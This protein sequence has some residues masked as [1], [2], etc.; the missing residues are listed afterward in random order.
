MAMWGVWAVRASD[1]IFGAA[2]SWV[3]RGGQPVVCSR[4]DAEKLAVIMRKSVCPHTENV[5][6]KAKLY[7]EQ[8]Q[9]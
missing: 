9:Q 8:G 2:E 3:T 7:S 1:S 6:Y 4:E 5:C